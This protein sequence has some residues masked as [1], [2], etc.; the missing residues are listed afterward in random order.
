[1]THDVPVTID[2]PA[3]RTQ[4]RD[5]MSRAYAPYSGYPVG[6]AA[7]VDDGRTVTGC[8]VEN[9]SYGLGLCAECGLV[10]ALFASGGGRLTAFT[11][12][13][14]KGE[15]LVPCGRCRQLLHEHG[16][17]DLLVDT[18]AGIRPL[19]ALLPDAFGPGHLTR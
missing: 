1:M 7:L 18:A 11:C 16:G 6:A 5:A 12:V 17:P 19:A 10:S 14:G 2:W 15:L 8:N 9:A 3:L 13:D 4:A